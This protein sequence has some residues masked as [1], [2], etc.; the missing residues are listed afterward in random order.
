MIFLDGQLDGRRLSL[1][2]DHS[3]AATLG[4]RP[5]TIGV[6]LDGEGKMQIKVRNFEQPG[7][8]T[9]I[10]GAPDNGERLTVQLGKQIPLSRGHSIGVNLPSACHFF[11]G[12]GA[13]APAMGS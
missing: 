1:A 12:D 9:Y 13:Q 8:V 6:S 11:G 10:D 7:S 3:G 2:E 4:F 5:E